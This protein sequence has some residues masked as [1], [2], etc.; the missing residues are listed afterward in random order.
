MVWLSWIIQVEKLKLKKREG[1]FIVPR[2]ITGIESKYCSDY[3]FLFWEYVIK[4]AKGKDSQTTTQVQA[5][6]SFYRYNFNPKSRKVY[7]LV[8]A[9]QFTNDFYNINKP[10]VSDYHNL[11][12]SIMSINLVIAQFKK[13]E[14]TVLEEDQK[15]LDKQEKPKTVL[16]EKLEMQNMIDLM[17]LQKSATKF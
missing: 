15:K 4:S 6:Y 11:I 2:N 5:L 8:T 12:K 3:L 16:D 17:L 1:I 10:V 7:L 14:K 9:I 13:Y